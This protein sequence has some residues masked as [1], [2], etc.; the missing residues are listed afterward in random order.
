VNPEG[1]LNRD[2]GGAG[3]VVHSGL[4]MNLPAGASGTKSSSQGPSRLD[5]A[6]EKYM[7]TTAE[8]QK[9]GGGTAKKA[10]APGSTTLPRRSAATGTLKTRA[11]LFL[12]RQ[13]RCYPNHRHH[14]ASVAL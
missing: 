11:V 9:R 7:K 3:G 1:I 10:P 4:V 13:R 6:M 14:A 5:L 2:G 12:V 8:A